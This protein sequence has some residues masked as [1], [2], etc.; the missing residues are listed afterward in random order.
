MIT[1][2]DADFSV[3]LF[4]ITDSIIRGSMHIMDSATVTITNVYR[5]QVTDDLFYSVDSTL[6]MPIVNIVNNMIDGTMMDFDTVNDI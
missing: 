5:C 4:N 2:D 3:A 6:S 1:S